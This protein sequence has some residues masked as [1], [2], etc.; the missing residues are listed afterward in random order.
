MIDVEAGRVVD[1]IRTGRGAHGVSVSDDGAFVFVTN[2][3]D[4]TISVI[5]VSSRKVVTSFAVGRGPNGITYRPS[6]M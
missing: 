6:P 4:D 5:D 3:V 1:T 2:I